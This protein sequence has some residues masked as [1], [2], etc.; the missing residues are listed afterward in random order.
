MH[1][2]RAGRVL[3]PVVCRLFLW[4]CVLP[5]LWLSVCAGVLFLVRTAVPLTPGLGR[6]KEGECG[7][8]PRLRHEVARSEWAR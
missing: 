7:G 3:A 5:V 6:G 2:G 8:R 1:L 4:L